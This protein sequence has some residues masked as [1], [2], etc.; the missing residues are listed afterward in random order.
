MKKL[1]ESITGK[2]FI[3]F[4]PL[5]LKAQ[6]ELLMREQKFPKEYLA[7]L[8]E[9][10]YLHLLNVYSSMLTGNHNYGKM[11]ALNEVRLC[12]FTIEYL[13]TC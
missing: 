1:A 6:T 2:S 11:Q 9:K 5:Q 12:I 7:V 13:F 3:L 8:Y 10:I 4:T